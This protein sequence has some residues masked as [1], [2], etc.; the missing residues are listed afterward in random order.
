MSQSGMWRLE[1]ESEEEAGLIADFM[2]CCTFKGKERE[3]G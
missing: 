2:S 1:D 3:G